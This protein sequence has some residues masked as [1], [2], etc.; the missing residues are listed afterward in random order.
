MINKLPI[1]L[2]FILRWLCYC[3][4][5]VA[6]AQLALALGRVFFPYFGGGSGV[7][8]IIILVF[9]GITTFTRKR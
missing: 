4:V 5:A 9:A 3:G 8:I 7:F 1:G 2:Q 6:V